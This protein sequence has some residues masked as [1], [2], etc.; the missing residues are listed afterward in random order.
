MSK[1]K[2]EQSSKVPAEETLPKPT[3][4]YL[5][6]INRLNSNYDDTYS[7]NVMC[8][9]APDG[10]VFVGIIVEE[11]PDSFLVGASATLR[12]NKNKQV[13]A[14]GLSTQPV[15]RLMKSAVHYTV[16]PTNLTVYHYFAFLEEFGYNTLP[17]Y[18]TDK[19]KKFISAVRAD[20]AYNTSM[21]LSPRETVTEA[22]G[23]HIHSFIPIAQSERIH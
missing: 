15:I 16:V 4:H 1:N 3:T 6:H 21:D 22:P 10:K 9:Y 13:L 5:G 11:T 2:T 12:M 18:F 23:D 19:R 8:F 7:P 17:E 14:E 20:E